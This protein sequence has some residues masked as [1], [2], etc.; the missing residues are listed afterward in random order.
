M[1]RARLA[2]AAQ[3]ATLATAHS[4]CSLHP[5][6]LPQEVATTGALPHLPLIAVLLVPHGGRRGC[7]LEAEAAQPGGPVAP[8]HCGQIGARSGSRCLGLHP[9]LR[10]CTWVLAAT[11]MAVR[12]CAT[13]ITA[14]GAPQLL[15]LLS[16][17]VG[18]C[19][20]AVARNR[21]FGLA[22]E[23]DDAHTASACG[24]RVHAMAHLHSPCSAVQACS[25]AAPTEL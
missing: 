20:Q 4:C 2:P 6:S 24:C 5:G 11:G 16:S 12:G 25:S 10:W 3:G 22:E 9:R 14:P 7:G 17:P 13:D 23:H 18:H 21:P 15:Y 1:G 8:Q 19:E